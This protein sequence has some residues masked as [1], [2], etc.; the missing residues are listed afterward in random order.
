VSDKRILYGSGEAEKLPKGSVI[1]DRY[2]D[3]G[4][5]LGGGVF[6]GRHEKIDAEWFS[7]PADVLYRP[8]VPSILRTLGELDTLPDGSVVTSAD[9]DPRELRGFVRISGHWYPDDQAP[10][11]PFDDTVRHAAELEGV[12]VVYRPV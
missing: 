5:A 8:E 9:G 1:Q 6:Q 11:S 4:V 3:V 7:Y 2:G 10:F 12:R